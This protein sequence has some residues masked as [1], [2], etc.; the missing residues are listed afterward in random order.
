MR[1]R[2]PVFA[3]ARFRSAAA[4]A[5]A[6]LA[7]AASAAAG[8]A[9]AWAG[10]H[11]VVVARLEGLGTCPR[12]ITGL[13]AQPRRVTREQLRGPLGRVAELRE[14]DAA[15][16]GLRVVDDQ[17]L[18]QP[19]P[20]QAL[21]DDRAT[22]ALRLPRAVRTVSPRRLRAFTACDPDLAL[23]LGRARRHVARTSRAAPPGLRGGGCGASPGA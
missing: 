8:R 13:R 15:V 20:A 22:R 18:A 1:A 5:G 10:R 19:H 14:R 11:C 17:P 21:E 4:S 3:G 23:G 6:G 16:E 7:I 9:A 2:H 12:P